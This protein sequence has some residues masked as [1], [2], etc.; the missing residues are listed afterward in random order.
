MKSD[1]TNARMKD[2]DIIERYQ[3]NL[4]SLKEISKMSGMCPKTIRGILVKNNIYIRPQSV[5]NIKN[6]KFGRL[7]AEEY[8]NNGKWQCKCECGN[9]KFVSGTS[10]RG[11]V[12]KS[13]G[14]LRTHSDR[15]R[16]LSEYKI[17]KITVISFSHTRK[18]KQNRS[19]RVWKCKCDCGKIIELTTTEIKSKYSCGCIK[20]PR[21]KVVKRKK[22]QNIM[23]IYRIVILTK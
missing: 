22:L 17:N 20:K 15:Q 18:L 23:V 6:Q 12:V 19:L 11:G 5:Q 10:L 21:D 13:C 1:K 14:C 16:D 8:L 4:R 2:S 3:N 9:I 7:I